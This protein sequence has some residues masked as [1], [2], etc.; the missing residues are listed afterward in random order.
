[1]QLRRIRNLSLVDTHTISPRLV[2][3]LRAGFAWHENSFRGP[4]RG[5]EIVRDLGI[6]GLTSTLDFNGVPN[7]NIT[8]FSPI[9]QI[10]H[11]RSQDMVLDFIDN[12]TWVVR[13]HSLKVGVN[14]RKQQA[15][16]EPIPITIFGR[17]DFTGAFTGFSYAD[18]LLGIPQTTQRTTPQGRTYGRNTVVAGYVQDDI[19]LHAKLTLNMGLRYEW[20]SPFA[21]KYDRMF[22]FDP[23]TGSIVVP[24]RA[25]IE[26]DVVPI[27]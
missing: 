6:R 2:N 26:R 21:D 12:L 4:L 8:G 16:R 14:F 19:K 7:I 20:M 18:F 22:N 27:F 1:D 9:T 3:E 23:K 15:P 5:L 24:T 25:V 11:Q 10:D 13:R 17:Y